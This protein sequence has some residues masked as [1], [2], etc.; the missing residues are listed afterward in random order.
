[1]TYTDR[2]PW[3]IFWRKELHAVPTEVR[4]P[5]RLTTPLLHVF[6][7]YARE[8]YSLDRRGSVAADARDNNKEG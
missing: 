2:D 8:N 4:W 3:Q 6:L 1:M 5:I 7:E